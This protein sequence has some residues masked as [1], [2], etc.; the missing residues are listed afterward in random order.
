MPFELDAYLERVE[1]RGGRAPTLETLH[2]LTR[3]HVTHIPFENLDPI[4]DRRVR[5]DLDG[6]FDKLVTRRRG[7][8]CFEQNGLL[9][10]AL[11]E[12]GFEVRAISARVRV[13][14]TRHEQAPRTHVFLLVA[15]GDRQWM[16]DLGVGALSLSSA[17]EFRLGGE[18]ETPHEPRRVL[19]ESGLFFHQAKLGD[20]WR[21][22]CEFTLEA[23]PQIDREIANW[24]VSTHPQSRLRATVQVA[25][26]L[27][28]GRRVTLRGCELTHRERDGR[29]VVRS[30]DGSA[31]GSTLEDHFDLRLEKE[32]VA[33]LVRRSNPGP[34]PG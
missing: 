17:I 33:E 22:V 23:M 26:A 31:F 15:L 5:L 7:G 18:Q 24:Y 21:D 19:F 32:D 10:H 4:L 2:A 12:L 3:A 14:R 16:T 28:D 13:D 30:V 27:P 25:R 20:A 8:Y 34:S 9:E 29:A 6:I 1:Y 11:L